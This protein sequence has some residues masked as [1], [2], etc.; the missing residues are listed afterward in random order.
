MFPSSFGMYWSFTCRGSNNLLL[1][2][3]ASLVR[4][5]KSQG[6]VPKEKIDEEVKRLLE[7]KCRLGIQPTKGSKKTKATKGH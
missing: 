7:L 1:S 4:Q 2:A 6:D 5:L 3:Q